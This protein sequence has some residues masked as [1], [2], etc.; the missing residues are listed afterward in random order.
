LVAVVAV[1]LLEAM[2][3][4]VESRDA[5]FSAVIISHAHELDHEPEWTS[6]WESY[7]AEAEIEYLDFRSW[8]IER[9]PVAEHVYGDGVHLTDAGSRMFAEFLYDE[10]A[11]LQ[12][13][14]TTSD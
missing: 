14:E 4:L 2:G 8:L 13:T 3:D 12:K 1:R 10:V 7:V 6:R 11:S 9:R 5:R